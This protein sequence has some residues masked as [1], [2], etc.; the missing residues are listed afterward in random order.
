MTDLFFATYDELVLLTK[1][2]KMHGSLSYVVVNILIELASNST[3][4][5]DGKLAIGCHPDTCPIRQGPS[6]PAFRT[7]AGGALG[8][9]GHTR[10]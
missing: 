10:S 4:Y 3:R 5:T 9:T 7:R 2:W 6:G 8:T 1:A